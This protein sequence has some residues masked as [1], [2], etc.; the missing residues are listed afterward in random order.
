MGQQAIFD[1]ITRR[2]VAEFSP[3]RIYL[4][5]SQA[6]GKPGLESD[7]DLMVIIPKSKESRYQ[8]AV[9]AHRVLAD[10]PVSK[11]VVVETDE[12]FAFRAQ[13]PSSLEH[14]ISR[15]GRLLYG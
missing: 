14:K 13:A 9:R 5:G 11:D 15:E 12:E 4:F 2:L 10:L 3:L 6:W 7:I 8:R 1:E